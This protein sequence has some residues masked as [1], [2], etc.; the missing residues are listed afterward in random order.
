MKTVLSSLLDNRSFTFGGRSS[1]AIW[2]VFRYV[3]PSLVTA[4]VMAS[5]LSAA[6]IGIGFFVFTMSTLTPFDNMGVMTMKMMSI[7]SMTSTIGVTLMSATGGGALCFMTMP[8][9]SFFAIC[10]LPG[11]RQEAGSPGGL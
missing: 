2:V 1:G 3:L 8:S 5:L 4:T 10:S 11:T 6:C 7:T 9:D